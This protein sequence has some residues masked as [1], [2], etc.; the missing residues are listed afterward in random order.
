MKKFRILLTSIIVAAS[1]GTTAF[2]DTNGDI[3]QKNAGITPDSI[4]YAI[5]VAFD[6]LKIALTSGSLKKAQV[7]LKVADERLS[8]SIVMIMKNKP[9]LAVD[10]VKK[11]TI[12]LTNAENTLQTQLSANKDTTDQKTE[13]NTAELEKKVTEAQNKGT[14]ALKNIEDKVPEKSKQ[15]ITNI[16][17]MQTA[18]REAVQNMVKKRHELNSARRDYNK[19]I[20]DLIKVEKSGDAQALDATKTALAACQTTYNNAKK[21]YEAA[22]AN[23]KEAVK[24]A[25]AAKKSAAKSDNTTTPTSVTT[26]TNTQTTDTTEAT[27]TSSTATVQKDDDNKANPANVAKPSKSQ[28]KN[29]NNS[30][31]E[32]SK[33]GEVHKNKK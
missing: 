23:K 33:N 9:E 3:N 29:H 11:Y 21:A 13:D 28:E 7:E 8:E 31:S 14:D 32:K 25:N 2:A 4:L 27:G 30:N 16:I 1:V 19:A 18:K 24:N 20:V 26:E 5:D 15:E 10:T 22:F 12:N 6:N 17:Q